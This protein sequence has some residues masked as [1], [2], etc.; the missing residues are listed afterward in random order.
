MCISREIAANCI[1]WSSFLTKDFVRCCLDNCLK[2]EVKS[3]TQGA[4]PEILDGY[5][6]S[7]LSIDAIKV[8]NKYFIF[9][10]VL[11]KQLLK[12]CSRTS[13]FLWKDP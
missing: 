6:H 8:N 13:A 9:M 12:N 3:W 11:C 5:Y 1:F 10:Y 7:E 2:I 4:E